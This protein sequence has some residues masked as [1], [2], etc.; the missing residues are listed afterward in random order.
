MISIN[1]TTPLP[2]FLIVTTI[3]IHK[4]NRKSTLK[5]TGHFVS[6]NLI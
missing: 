6:Q 2:Y 1:P 4:F 5:E 3:A